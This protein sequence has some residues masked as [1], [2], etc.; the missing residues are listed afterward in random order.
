MRAL[1][2]LI[3]GFVFGIVLTK[4]EAVSWYRIYEMFHFQSF[5]MYGIIMTAVLTGLIGIQFI[6]RM[7]VKDIKGEPI[8][9][10]DKEPGSARYW[11]GGL[12]F[13]F[14]WAMVGA[15]PG[16]IFILLGAGF[17]P[18][19]FILAGAL[20]GTFIYGVVKDRLPH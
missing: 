19:I 20:V 12:F 8:V 17:L 1:K 9:I 5:H 2:Y 13:G 16:P 3:V 6:R 14:G 4:S 11:V 10:A 15:C 18:V 7:K